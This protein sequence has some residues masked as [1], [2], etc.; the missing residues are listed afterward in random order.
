MEGIMFILVLMILGNGI[1]GTLV[2]GNLVAFLVLLFGFIT[3]FIVG[4][5]NVNSP[6]G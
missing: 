1:C 5:N 6:R 3:F 4:K 2:H